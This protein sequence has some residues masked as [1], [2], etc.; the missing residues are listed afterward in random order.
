MLEPFLG[1][2]PGR[3][4]DVP[5][6]RFATA[7]PA[8]AYGR[9]RCAQDR[10]VHGPGRHDPDPPVD[11]VGLWRDGHDPLWPHGPTQGAPMM[12]PLAA[13]PGVALPGQA[14]PGWPLLAAAPPGR[15]LRFAVTIARQT[16]LP[17]TLA[18][19]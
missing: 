3:A 6:L 17:M 9:D 16:A 19:T 1:G 18:R 5:Q 14:L 7:G 8:V 12:G 11:E 13:V 10:G 15:A 2:A 4:H